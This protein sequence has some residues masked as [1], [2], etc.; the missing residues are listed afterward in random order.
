[1]NALAA[2]R[3]HPA[4]KLG[5]V[6]LAL[7]F[8][9]GLYAVLAPSDRAS[10]AAVVDE[11]AI[12]AG[13]ALYNLN[14]ASCHGLNL[15]GSTDGPTLLGVG[16]AAVDF[17]VGTG[18]MPAAGSSTVQVPEKPVRFTDEQIFQ[19]AAFVAAQA[20]G[21][22]I[23]LISEED[24]ADADLVE[25]GEL[26]RTN[27]SMCHGFAGSGGA[28]TKGKYA[29]AIDLEE[30][31]YVYEAMLTGPQSMPVFSD[32]AALGPE[33]KFAIIA[34]LDEIEDDPSPGLTL[35]QLGTVPEGLMAWIGGLG[36]LVGCCIWL[37]SKAK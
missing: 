21:P 23:P 20:P 13:E 34:W 11:D 2:R 36:L 6:L 26:F 25:G 15:Q 18:R 30:P 35:G 4:A 31:R 24:I 29:P 7:L 12:A 37:G 27:C 9:G 17:Q 3:H 22:P 32:S 28:L 16:A 14:C 1:V 8:T 33:E 5:V 10:A 19:L